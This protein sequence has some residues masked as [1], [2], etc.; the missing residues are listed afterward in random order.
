MNPAVSVE[1]VVEL[2]KLWGANVASPAQN[3]IDVSTTP[4]N[5]LAIVSELA[6]RKWVSLSP[7]FLFPGGLPVVVRGLGYEH[8]GGRLV[9]RF[10]NSV[11]LR[12]FQPLTAGLW[13]R[14]TAVLVLAQVPA[15]IVLKTSGVPL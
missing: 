15:L 9:V 3:L 12:W 4:A 5:V 6:R 10:D 1:S 14:I 2:V 8:V 7:P 13:W 11:G